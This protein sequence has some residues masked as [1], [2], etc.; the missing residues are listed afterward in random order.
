MFD[1]E[2]IDC[3]LLAQ[4]IWYMPTEAAQPACYKLYNTHA[5]WCWILLGDV[6]FMPGVR[7]L[8]TVGSS[9]DVPFHSLAIKLCGFLHQ[10]AL[11]STQSCSL[12]LSHDD[13]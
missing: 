5:L 12:D 7:Q 10:R 1:G 3:L 4:K 9:A 2:G 6:P 13:E 8:A 11:H